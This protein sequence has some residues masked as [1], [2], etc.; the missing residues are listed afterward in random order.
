MSKEKVNFS[1]ALEIGS[2]KV[3]MVLSRE[4]N[5]KLEVIAMA[6]VLHK[7]IHQGQV[8]DTR[9]VTAAI[10]KVKAEIELT[11]GL[12]VSSAFL[13]VVDL[14]NET[15]H[16]K[17][18]LAVRRKISHKDIE[19]AVQ[20]ATEAAQVR[21]DREILHS[22]PQYFKIGGV[23]HKDA[24][25]GQT[26]NALEAHVLLVTGS[27]K[28][29]Q[30]AR[31]CA[32]GAGLEVTA[33]IAHPIAT[34]SAITRTEDHQQGIAV[35]DVGGSI[36][37]IVAFKDGKLAFL[38]SLAIGGMNFT[39]D[40]A[41]G[42]RTPQAAAE[43]I[44]KTHGA[45]LV[46]L[47]S[48]GEIVEIESLKG[49]P[50]RKVEAQFIC[51]ILEA[52]AEETLGLILKKLN[53]EDLLFNLKGGVLVTGGGSQLPGF[54]ELGE[55]TFDIPLRRGVTHNIVSTGPLAQGPVMATAIGVLQYTKKRQAFEPSELSIDTLK[56][57]WGKIKT[58]IENI[59]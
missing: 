45:A 21:S 31:D 54:P 6:Q 32:Y 18:T 51:E 25:L 14:T 28:N 8:V 50:A 55:F 20:T 47:V 58:F 1:A 53:D 22:F 30:A 43:K 10:A 29:I 16:A 40:L 7:G 4:L 23:K 39:Q 38:T 26:A 13:T 2:S 52:R 3:A 24:P 9:E 59:L 42:L 36:T 27:K 41:V 56:N 57:S 35:V 34:A 11:S 5:D 44:K 46:D 37:D 15:L 17:A 12:N 33:V 19:Q 49:E 48:S